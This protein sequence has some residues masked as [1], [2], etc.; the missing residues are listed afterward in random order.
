[1]KER[2]QL[3]QLCRVMYSLGVEHGVHA[4]CN[5]KER[6][7]TE[8]GMDVYAEIGQEEVQRFLPDLLKLYDVEV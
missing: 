7:K 6:L 5:I 8:Y 4:S 1:M 2:V 3:E